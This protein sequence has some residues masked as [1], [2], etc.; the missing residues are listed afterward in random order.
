[1]SK[2][3]LKESVSNFSFDQ[4]LKL[5]RT[6]MNILQWGMVLYANQDAIIVPTVMIVL[7]T[8][9]FLFGIA[10]VVI[11]IIDIL[12]PWRRRSKLVDA[13]VQTEVRSRDKSRV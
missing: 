2:P 9:S 4:S 13:A 10:E 1:M 6:A 11:D 12:L 3:R 8:L 7:G 5:G